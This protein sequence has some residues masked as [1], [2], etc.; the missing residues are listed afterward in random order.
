MNNND[1][2][3]FVWIASH[4]NYLSISLSY[5]RIEYLD[6]KG[7]P[8]YQEIEYTEIPDDAEILRKL[9]DKAIEAG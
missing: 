9:V 6:D 8:S 3:R 7:V 1:A 5:A 4:L 2:D